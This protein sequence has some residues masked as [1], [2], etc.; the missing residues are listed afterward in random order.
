M[1]DETGSSGARLGG[2]QI[3][4]D[5]VWMSGF[6]VLVLLSIILGVHAFMRAYRLHLD[7]RTGPWI[8]NEL[9]SDDQSQ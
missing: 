4:R 6:W 1:A 8:A 3:F 2:S 9:S 5:D 7:V